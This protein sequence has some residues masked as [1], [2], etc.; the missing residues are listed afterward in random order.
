MGQLQGQKI[1]K[2]KKGGFKKLLRIKV[3]KKLNF[4][5]HMNDI[6]SK[7]VCVNVRV[8][9]CVSF[10]YVLNGRSLPKTTKS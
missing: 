10:V 8:Y 5:G 3:D 1:W 2:L 7:N 4:N 6:I 9:V